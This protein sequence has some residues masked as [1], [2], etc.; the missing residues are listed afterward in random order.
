MNDGWKTR[1]LPASFSS[2]DW[3]SLEPL[4]EGTT[5]NPSA[6]RIEELRTLLLGRDDRWDGGELGRVLKAGLSLSSIENAPGLLGLPWPT[7]DPSEALPVTVKRELSRM[8]DDGDDPYLKALKA[9]TETR[10]PLSTRLTEVA[11]LFGH[12]TSRTG[13]NRLKQEILPWFFDHIIERLQ[14]TSDRLRAPA[15]S[16]AAEPPPTVIRPLAD[17]GTYRGE[18]QAPINPT[19]LAEVLKGRLLQIALDVSDL[20]EATRLA[21]I[22]AAN[23][24]DLIEVGDPLIK[25]FGMKSVCR[26]R[27]MVPGMP[28]VVE[29]ASSDWVDEQIELAVEAGAD[30]VFVMGLDQPSR[31]E[32]AVRTARSHRVGIVLAI[33]THVDVTQWCATVESAGADGISIIR[34]I[35]SAEAAA[36]TMARMRAVADTTAVPVVIS[37]GFGPNN[38]AD[39][40]DDEWS[41]LIVGGAFIRARDPVAVMQ[42]LREMVDSM[43]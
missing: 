1:A 22:A 33:P 5:M 8:I 26:I 2:T 11:E 23:G 3:K 40:A 38:I 16:G 34:N 32:R 29:F 4:D 39:V 14:R 31:I 20:E 18:L 19:Q 17:H 36:A 7:D 41:V 30:L 28:I 37:G 42:I 27:E 10:K 12:T 25:R 15:S 21:Q 35:D 24:A 13:R 9:L 43:G 6:D